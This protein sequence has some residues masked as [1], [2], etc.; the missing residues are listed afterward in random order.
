MSVTFKVDPLI[1]DNYR[2]WKAQVKGL[3]MGN[4]LW[5]LVIGEDKKPAAGADA[6]I[7]WI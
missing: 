5:G 6:I 1:A 3:L 7:T 2:S 4:D